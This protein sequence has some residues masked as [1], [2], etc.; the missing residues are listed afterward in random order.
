M[1]IVD[2]PLRVRG[3]CAATDTRT[4]RA[5]AGARTSHGRSKSQGSRAGSRAAGP[6]GC[7]H[8][9]TQ[10]FQLISTALRRGVQWPAGYLPA[11]F[12]HGRRKIENCNMESAQRAGWVHDPQAKTR[13]NNSTHRQTHPRLAWKP[14]AKAMPN[15]IGSRASPPWRRPVLPVASQHRAPGV[16]DGAQIRDGSS[17]LTALKAPKSINFRTSAI[18]G[19]RNSSSGICESNQSCTLFACETTDFIF[20]AACCYD[21]PSDARGFRDK[22]PLVASSALLV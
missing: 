17:F 12:C 11:H 20:F 16:N 21:S 3:P 9:N 4:H 2:V 5:P 19:S 1:I 13:K 6:S 18:L 7:C 15:A 10:Q 22:F 14:K 8:G